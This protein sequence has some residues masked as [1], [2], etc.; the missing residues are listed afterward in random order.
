MSIVSVWLLSLTAGLPMCSSAPLAGRF[1]ISD[2][3]RY[4]Q[5]LHMARCMYTSYGCL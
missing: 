1:S 3:C 4:I 2:T 5:A